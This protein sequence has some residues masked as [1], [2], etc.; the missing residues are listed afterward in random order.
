VGPRSGLDDVESRKFCGTWAVS[1]KTGMS[2]LLGNDPVNILAATNT[3]KNME[4]IVI[5]RF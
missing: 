2:L 5:T 4:Y 3:D 1:I